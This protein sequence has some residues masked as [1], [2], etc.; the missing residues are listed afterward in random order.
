MNKRRLINARDLLYP[1]PSFRKRED[2]CTSSTLRLAGRKIGSFLGGKII[3][4]LPVEAAHF[5]QLTDCENRGS[6]SRPRSQ[7]LIP[8]VIGHYREALRKFA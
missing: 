1:Y 6:L 7:N 5:R 2:T 8:Q 3:D 4:L